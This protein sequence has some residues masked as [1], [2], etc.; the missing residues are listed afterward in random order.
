MVNDGLIS[1][2]SRMENAASLPHGRPSD[3][4]T[5]NKLSSRS[6]ADTRHTR[7]SRADSRRTRPPA[8]HSRPQRRRG[9]RI[10]FGN[11]RR[12]RIR[13]VGGWSVGVC[14]WRRIVAIRWRIVGVRHRI[15]VAPVLT[16]PTDV[17]DERGIGTLTAQSRYGQRGRRG[18][19][20]AA[21]T[22]AHNN[23]STEK[24]MTH[25]DLPSFKSRGH[26]RCGRTSR[27]L[28]RSR[29]DWLRSIEAW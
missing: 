17:L 2:L 29:F 16:T 9:R 5:R 20:Q 11:R 10:R 25:H 18:G 24:Q 15:A 4:R 26:V 12:W 22:Y 21:K 8:M 7:R 3:R 1:A 28:T 6:R 27:T 23:R 14:R 19:H 13:V